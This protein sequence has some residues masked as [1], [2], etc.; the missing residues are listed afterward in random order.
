MKISV[1]SHDNDTYYERLSA[2]LRIK[3][4]E[5]EISGDYSTIY[6]CT[7][8]ECSVSGPLSRANLKI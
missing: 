6:A 3:K 1:Y 8:L 7:K 4:S 2:N 5:I